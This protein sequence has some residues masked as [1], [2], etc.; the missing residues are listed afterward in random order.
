[1]SY[2]MSDYYSDAKRKWVQDEYEKGTWR[3]PEMEEYASKLRHPP[4]NLTWDDLEAWT[5]DVTKDVKEHA[6]T[7]SQRE[8]S[9][10]TAGAAGSSRSRSPDERGR[11]SPPDTAG[12]AGSSRS[13]SPDERGRGSPTPPLDGEILRLRLVVKA[14]KVLVRCWDDFRLVMSPEPV[15]VSHEY[16]IGLQSKITEAEVA[17][18]KAERG[19]A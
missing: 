7:S 2:E 8:R 4:D 18:E 12:A 17:V 16:F 3:L 14:L 5:K 11:G 1:M 10:D 9:P 19:I 15:D 13:R 6:G